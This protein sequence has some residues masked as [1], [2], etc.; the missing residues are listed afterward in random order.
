MLMLAFSLFQGR[1]IKAEDGDY[2][3][4]AIFP[5]GPEYEDIPVTN[6]TT[7]TRYREAVE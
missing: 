5:I 4:I 6:Y 2:G 1:T 7:I 3:R